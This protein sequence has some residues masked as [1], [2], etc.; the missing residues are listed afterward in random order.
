[1]SLRKRRRNRR[2]LM[3]SDRCWDA[4]DP[5]LMKSNN[6]ATSLNLAKKLLTMLQRN[7]SNNP[8]DGTL[9]LDWRFLFWQQLTSIPLIKT[10]FSRGFHSAGRRIFSDFATSHPATTFNVRVPSS[11]VPTQRP[12]CFI[13]PDFLLLLIAAEIWSARDVGVAWLFKDIFPFA[14][15]TKP[16]NGKCC[17]S[18]LVSQPFS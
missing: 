8:A 2:R 13:L 10:L 6:K 17:L 15:H 14:L 5:Q 18:A 3:H 12:P 7:L 16:R 1:M 4:S 11:V 9:R